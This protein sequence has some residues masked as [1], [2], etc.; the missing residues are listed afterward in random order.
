MAKKILLIIAP[1]DFRDEELFV[2][3]E[4]LDGKGYQTEIA[5]LKKEVI[6]GMLG[7]EAKP[8][9]TLD[10]AA[11]RLKDYSAVVFIGGSG[12]MTY[13]EN[14]LALEIAKTAH[15]E[16]KVVA[17]ICIAPIIL[18]NAGILEGK[19]ATVFNGKYAD[20]LKSKGAKYKNEE[21]VVDGKVVTANGPNA[22]RKFGET[23]AKILEE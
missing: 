20:M 9:L 15:K 1:K 10:E 7:G 21:V 4:V 18:A 23:I 5:S 17:A 19:E 2:T 3:K 22:A 11:L 6:K 8:D 13:F 16:G 14:D 12:A